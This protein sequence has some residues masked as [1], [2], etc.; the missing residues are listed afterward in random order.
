[1]KKLYAHWC[2][3]DNFGDAL[4]PY[5][6]NKLSGC[7]VIYCNYKFPN[8]YS[9]IKVLI[10]NI[11]KLKSVDVFRLVPPLFWKNKKVI[12]AVGSILDRSRSNYLIWGAGYMNK[13]EHAQGGQLYAVRG[14]YSAKKLHSEGFPFCTVY[15][16]PA[17]LLP[18]VYT[19]QIEK[20][21]ECGLIPHLKDYQS[22]KKIYNSANIINLKT[23][24]IEKT[25]DRIA[26]CKFILSTSLHG[27]IVAHA[28]GIPA[29][30]IK[31]GD[32]STDGIKFQD[33][34]SSVNIPPYW[35]NFDMS[36]LIN[37]SYDEI[38]KDI[39]NLM[40]PQI[41]ISEVQKSLIKVCPF[42][43]L[44]TVKQKLLIN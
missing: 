15:G 22:V 36:F 11:L 34:F 10:K 27:I 14:Y 25:I 7:K 33:Y 23:E 24:N 4:N 1:M 41:P 42:T 44:P 5:L 28:Y 16:D 43:I 31:K 13:N 30:W 26:S 32:I 19:P 17:I 39:K 38:P 35:G 18:L 37:K 3:I 29:L 12:L 9:E 6:L 2:Y 21:Y 40:L 20:K 8:Y